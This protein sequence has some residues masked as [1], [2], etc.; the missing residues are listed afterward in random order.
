M[1]GHPKTRGDLRE[2]RIA[3][4]VP[5]LVL[6]LSEAAKDFAVSEAEGVLRTALHSGINNPRT[7]G[8]VV[9]DAWLKAAR[10]SN[11]HE[12]KADSE[13]QPAP[14]NARTQAQA[15]LESLANLVEGMIDCDN[16]RPKTLDDLH[17]FRAALSEFRRIPR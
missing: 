9:L 8:T 4:D 6:P 2:T 16:I 11:S 13:P 12:V 15:L 1:F 17:E 7:L 10:G 14:A 5:F 3:L